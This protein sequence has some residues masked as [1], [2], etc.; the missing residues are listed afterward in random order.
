MPASKC[1]TSPLK[2]TQGRHINNVHSLKVVKDR[3]SQET[4]EVLSELLEHAR[5][6]E[7][8]G[9][10]FAAMYKQRKFIVH[11]AGE[12]CREP[13]FTVGMLDFLSYKVKQGEC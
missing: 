5:R 12:A 8:I 13:I 2:I 4:I 6:G 3:V 7:V 1:R 11:T 9:I 10:A